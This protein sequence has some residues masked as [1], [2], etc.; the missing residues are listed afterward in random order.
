MPGAEHLRGRAHR[1]ADEHRVPRSAQGASM[2]SRSRSGGCSCRS[3]SAPKSSASAPG[4]A[5]IVLQ[6]FY[7][8]QIRRQRGK[9]PESHANSSASGGLERRRPARINGAMARYD[10]RTPQA[11]RRGPARRGR[12]GCRSRASRRTTCV[13]VLRLKPGADVLVFNGR[14]G[15]WRAQLAAAGKK[16]A[17]LAVVERTREQTAARRPALPVL[18][19]QARAPRLHGAEGGRDGRLAAAAGA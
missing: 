1:Q 18:A 2:S 19:A 5:L 17:Q 8:A 10:F 7:R 3:P 9:V 4:Q 12:D 11:V 16:A 15:E 13:N 14:D 6:G